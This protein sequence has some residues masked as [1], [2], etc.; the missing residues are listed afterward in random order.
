M[1]ALAVV[2]IPTPALPVFF[3][4]LYTPLHPDTA[5]CDGH[6]SQVVATLLGGKLYSTRQYTAAVL[7]CVRFVSS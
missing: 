5:P 7:L 3:F 2:V 1:H 6:V 4:P